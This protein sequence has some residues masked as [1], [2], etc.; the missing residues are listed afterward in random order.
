MNVLYGD[1]SEEV[2]L[3]KAGDRLDM[4]QLYESVYFSLNTNELKFTAAQGTMYLNCIFYLD[5][6][7]PSSTP[8]ASPLATPTATPMPT[9][10][11]LPT[12]FQYDGDVFEN[13]ANG[14]SSKNNYL[15]FD[16]PVIDGSVKIYSVCVKCNKVGATQRVWI[17]VFIKDGIFEKVDYQDVLIHDSIK[18]TS[19]IKS[20]KIKY[21]QNSG[22]ISYYI[23]SVNMHYVDHEINNLKCLI[24]PMTP[25]PTLTPTPLPTPRT[26]P[27]FIN[28]TFIGTVGVE[29]V[30]AG[31]N[32]IN[33]ISG[34]LF[35]NIHDTA[36]NY[37]IIINKEIDIHNNTFE[38]TELIN[39]NVEKAGIF[40]SAFNG[41]ITI[42]NCKFI[43]ISGKG[44]EGYVFTS[45]GNNN[46]QVTMNNC[47]FVDCGSLKK[48]NLPLI[49]VLNIKSSITFNECNFT[50]NDL[51]RNF[52]VL[53][54]R[55]NDANIN[56]CQFYQCGSN[57]LFLAK[58]TTENEPRG[59]FQFTN[60]HVKNNKGTFINGMKLRNKPIIEGN[61]F[62]DITIT[63]ANFISIQH[64]QPLIE[65]KNNTFSHFTTSFNSYGGGIASL[66]QHFSYEQITLIYEDC[67]FYDI[68][69]SNSQTHIIKVGQFNMGI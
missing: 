26:D 19:F 69:N 65:L 53:D 34:C 6:V 33:E 47:E 44:D 29:Q 58:D 46:I 16:C 15:Q 13:I 68:T 4:I 2:I 9:T 45:N 51:S 18:L 25:R 60:N 30:Q 42:N 20:D 59:T 63:N 55:T 39:S 43:R 52:R 7:P 41:R 38:N 32:N 1:L 64:N 23:D 5:V 36:R 50:F 48:P 37:Y 54:L 10:S 17:E 66:Y 12:Q 61:I 31:D 24:P 35:T 11:P 3:N 27:N 28:N 62:E 21:D 8:T 22:V 56:N 49:T 67:K 57:T 40:F 14:T